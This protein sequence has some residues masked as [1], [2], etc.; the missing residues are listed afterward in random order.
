MVG[1]VIPVI[2]NDL[3][4]NVKGELPNLGFDRLEL[5]LNIDESGEG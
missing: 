2:G 3:T 4:I 5:I 1:S